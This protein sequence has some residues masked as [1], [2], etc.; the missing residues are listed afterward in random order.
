MKKLAAIAVAFLIAVGLSAVVSP[1]QAAYPGTVTTYCHVNFKKF[2][3]RAG[4]N[5]PVRFSATTSGTGHPHGTVKVV[6][7]SH[8]HTYSRLY[9]YS[10]GN[11]YHFFPKMKRGRYQVHMRFT[12]RSGSVYKRCAKWGH[13]V[14]VR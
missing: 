5:D 2:V 9:A 11:N 10:G 8:K 12:P 13:R 6:A 7:Q 4:H 14:R 1:A 3:V